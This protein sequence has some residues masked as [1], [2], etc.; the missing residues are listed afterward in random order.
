MKN[1]PVLN[2]RPSAAKCA[3]AS[4][5]RHAGIAPQC[6]EQAQTLATATWPEK[7]EVWANERGMLFVI[8]QDDVLVK[9]TD[10]DEA[11]EL[12]GVVYADLVDGE[13]DF[14]MFANI[15]FFADNG[16]RKVGYVKD[17]VV[18]E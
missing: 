3:E 16:Y 10:T 5:I 11:G 18:I 12:Y 17:M 15:K 1:V 6:A 8:L 9:T 14:P 2:K 13:A 4:S 7:G